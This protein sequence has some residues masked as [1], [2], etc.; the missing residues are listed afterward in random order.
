MKL[1]DT[2]HLHTCR[3]TPCDTGS[4]NNAARTTSPNS[5]PTMFIFI[6]LEIV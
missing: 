5:H 6:Y 2:R 1:G 3:S 4:N